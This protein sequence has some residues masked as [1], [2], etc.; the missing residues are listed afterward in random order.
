MKATAAVQP[1]AAAAAVAAAARAARRSRP[2]ASRRPSASSSCSCRPS[3]WCAASALLLV[4]GIFVALGL[5]ADGRL[6]G[7]RPLLRARGPTCR[8]CCRACARTAAGW[9]EAFATSAAG[10]AVWAGGRAGSAA[11]GRGAIDFALVRPRRVL[12]VGPR[13]RSRRLG[14]RHPDQGDLGRARARAARPP[15]AR[16][17]ERPAGGDRRLRR[18]RRDPVGRRPDRPDGDPV[19]DG[20]SR[21]A[22]SRRT[23]TR[24]ARRARRTTTRPSCARRCRCPDLFRSGTPTS[25]ASVRA[26]LDAVPPYFSQA[27]ISSDRTHGHAGVRDPVDAARP[28]EGGDRRHREP[29]RP[30]R[31]AWTPPSSGCRCSPPRRTTP[32]PTRCGA[33]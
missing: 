33:S 7:A 4:I 9:W 1:G 12:M 15:G 26:L 13:G 29:A 16:G 19:D 32:W 14:G 17:R 5:R 11:W 28:P 23:A 30:A 3:R 2:P 18:D 27:V 22:C 31:R 20:A 25:E 24:S 6:R 8:P 10:R 21:P